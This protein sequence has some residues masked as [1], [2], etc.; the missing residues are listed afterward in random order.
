MKILIVEDDELN[1]YA[2]TAVLTNQNYAVEVGSD[3]ITAW[4]L[5]QTYD[6]DLILLDVILPRLD[7]ISLC[8]QIRSSGRQMPILLLTG[9]DSSHEKAIGLDAGADDYVVKPFDEEEL[10]ARVRALLRRGGTTAQPILE[11][12]NLQLDPSS[13]EVR[14]NQNLLSLT[15]K[16]YALLELFLRHSRRVFSCSMILEH[17]WS[18]EDTPGEE[19]VRTHIKGLRMKLR[20]AGAPGDLVETVYGI[21]YR[22]KAQEEE[23]GS[24]DEVKHSQS[25]SK[26]K[27]QQQTLTAIAGIWQKFYGRV[28]EQVKVLEQAAMTS[29]RPEIVTLTQETL[30]PELRSQAIREAHTLAGSLGTFGLP[31]GS[32]LA[33]KIE[34]LLKSG[35]KLTPTEIQSLQNWVKL[36]RQEVAAHEPQAASPETTSAAILQLQPPQAEAKVLAVDDDPQILAILQTLLHPWGLQ[37]ITLDDP[38]QF[39]E[40]LR[41]VNP[42]LLILDVEMP[43]T[44]G[45]EL[46]QVVRNDP[47]WS[48]L[49]ILFLTV[50]KDGEIVNQVFSV[51]ADD[52]VSKPI[53]GPE[54]V[55]RIINRLERVKLLHKVSESRGIGEKNSPPSPSFTD[56]R[57]I[58]NAE[59]ECVTIVATDGTLLDINPA[60]VAAI[61]ADSAG[62]VIG[63]RVYSLVVPEYQQVFR[64][65]NESVCQGEQGTLEFEIITCRGNRRWMATHAVPVRNETDGNLVQLS[66]T[67]DVTQYKQAELEIKRIN[68]TLQTLSDCNQLVIRTQDEGELLQKVCQILVDVGNYRLAWVAFAEN[69]AEKSIHP[70]AQAGYEQGYLQS[71]NLTWADTIRGQGP[72]GTAIRTGKTAIIQNILT[73]PR[74]EIW[75]CQASNRG[76]ASSI[77]LP[78]MNNGQAFGA[79]NIYAAEAN[80]FDSDEVKLLEELTA[81][82]AYGIV[83]LRNRRDRQIAEAALRE[84]QERLALTLEAVNLGIWDWNITTNQIIWS[85][86][87]ARLFGIESEKFDGTYEA[88]QACIYPE[89]RGG[90]AEVIN[91]ARQQKTDYSHEFR[92]ISPDGNIHWIE[93]TGKLYYNEMGEAVR[94]LGIVRDITSRKQIEA[95]LQKVNNELELRVAE[96]TAELVNVNRQLQSELDERQ[97]VEEALRISQVRLARILDIADDAII[98][99]NGNQQI[100][101]FN[102]GAEKIFGYSAE[103]II[104]Q[105]LD[106][107]IPQRFTQ[108]H[109]QHVADFGQAPNLARRMGERREIFGRRQDGTEFPAEASIS[110]FQLDKEVFYTVILRDITERKQI[111]RMKDEF[112]SVVSHELRTPLT[113]IHG[114]L[115][116]LASGL[117]PAD[118]E[119]GRRLL[120]IATDS[121]ER[122]VRLIND[123]LDIERIESGRVKMERE[124]CNLTDLIESAVSIMRPLANKAGVK[125]SVSHPSIQLWVDPDRIV[126]TLT[127]LLSN[128]IKFS[129][130]E[131]T[132]WLVAQ[133]Y[134]DELLVTV[135]D[136]GRGIPADKLDSIFERFQQVDSSDSRNHDGTG[137]GL[138]ICQSIVQQHGG[139]IWAESVLSEG[140]NFYFT[141]PILPISPNSELPDSLTHYP[142]SPEGDLPSPI[143]STH[144]PLV[145][146]CDD[147]PLIR[148][149]L[150]SL[151]EQG[152]YRVVTVATGKEAIASASTQHP[153]VIVLDLLMPGMNGWE[154][155]AML[156]ESTET[157]HIPIVICS[158]YK[159]TTNNQPSSDFVDWISKPVQESYLLHSLRQAIAKSSRRVRILIVED[160]ADLAELFVTLFERHDIE[161]FSA[162]TGREAIHLSQEVNPDLLILDLILP[163]TDGFAVVDW[164]QKH[165]RLCNI[166][167]VVYSA[168]DLDESER[169]RLKLG[170]TEFLTKGRVTTKEFEQRVIELL[171]RITPTNVRD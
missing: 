64:Q 35:K 88:F 147:D 29:D 46:C 82:V 144:S 8:R 152:G 65:L 3:G 71:L 149:E 67:R 55:T 109:R 22:L 138:A 61:E 122:L 2:L 50:H 23:Q 33:R 171:Q 78:L 140:S 72:T 89:D 59:P 58:F 48:E 53:V 73:D 103:A 97:R 113:S 159:P 110:K 25:T 26:G 115:G 68:R 168:K 125:L 136:N 137:L 79:L 101:L 167:V 121:T 17:I 91:S 21:G 75:R 117:L 96:R 134:G 28:D 119:Q 92:I 163:E 63:K 166:P 80:A 44:N 34:Q 116:M 155:M 126:Q 19:A 87:H 143:P 85:E 49:P 124:S 11:W 94:M 127:N 133:Q 13:C 142:L 24:K 156:K 41:D 52:F 130:A 148:T 39:W 151:L 36:L 5:I 114:S 105:R 54:L 56:W 100:T 170:H 15:P 157:K 158:V 20:N 165:Q 47:Q 162:K 12:G 86:G 104:G 27:S 150:Q 123:I 106:T 62:A 111:E 153:D 30:N 95:T 14:Y 84:S 118:S 45:I 60:G 120:E 70:V 9:C 42:D 131:K 81:D 10:V 77:S 99:I 141:L 69:D 40:T 161:T 129:T 43:Y 57:T 107:L 102:Q 154:T 169:K 132:V 18:Y 83:A 4:E 112:V 37:V 139:R 38:R 164:L 66:I 76:Y 146:V 135:K 32:K 98:S 108:A 93:G 160:D 7:G 51:G 1:A 74:F 31:E 128:A 90:L 6:Y 16:E 145:L